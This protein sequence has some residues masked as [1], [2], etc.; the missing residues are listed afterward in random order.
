MNFKVKKWNNFDVGL[1]LTTTCFIFVLELLKNKTP[2][3]FCL[4]CCFQNVPFVWKF[5]LFH[6]CVYVGKFWTSQNIPQM[7]WEFVFLCFQSIPFSFWKLS[8]SWFSHCFG[9][10]ENL[11]HMSPPAIKSITHE[12]RPGLWDLC[13]GLASRGSWWSS[14]GS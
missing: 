6:N 13:R 2:H 11:L 9:T 4:F 1:G 3:T 14:P 12:L 10:F 5:W 8:F 7:L